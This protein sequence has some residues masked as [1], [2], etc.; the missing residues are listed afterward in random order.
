MTDRKT[1]IENYKKQL[2]EDAQKELKDHSEI[3]KAFLK[4]CESKNINLKEENIIYLQKIGI[5]ANFPNIVNLLNPKIEID[6]EELVE[7]NIFETEYEKKAFFQGYFF[8]E[9]YMVMAHPYFRRSHYEENNFAPRFID[10]F[11]NYSNSNILKYISIDFD[12][13]RINVNTRKHV[14]FDTWFGAKF[15]EKIEAI[16]DGIIKLRPPAELDE[17]DIEFFFGGVYSLDIKWTSYDN[18][19]VFQSEEFKT[20]KNKIIKNGIEYYPVK[21]IHAEYDKTIKMFRHFDG[22]IHFYTKDEYLI[23]K[24]QDFN[25]NNK[26]KLQ[27]KTL[28]QK[29]FKINGEIPVK[30]W[31]ELT[32]HYL[33]SDP[34]IFE[35]FEGKTPEHITDLLK[36]IKETE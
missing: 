16:E 29:L 8:S 3:I 7:F 35:Y 15:N 20:E 12:R 14:E 18:I 25:Y 31:V 23:R 2:L 17:F 33:T 30:D 9:N 6:K 36:K 34:L 22:A 4:F 5:V 21:Y 19:K 24:D 26:N 10:I 32:S 27:L 1:L 13:V 28:S 11:W